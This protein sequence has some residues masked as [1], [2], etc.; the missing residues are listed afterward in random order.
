MARKSTSENGH[1]PLEEAMATL[2]NTQAAL[3][4]QL[5]ETSRQLLKHERESADTFA[6]IKEDM[7]AILQVLAEHSRLLQQLP[8]AIREKIGFRT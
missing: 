5:A 8:E 2:I 6:R 4:G 1:S 3:S 7:S